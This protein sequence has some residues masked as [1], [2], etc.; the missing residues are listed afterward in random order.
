MTMRRAIGL[1]SGT[2]LDGIDVALIESDGKAIRVTRSGNDRVAAL[3]PT[4]YRGYSDEER[5]LLT[6][7]L[8]DAESVSARTDRPGC[9]P[10]AEAFLT[11]AHAEAVEALLAENGLTPADIAV[12]GFHGQTV[13]HRPRERLTVQIGDGAALARRL[14]I[15]VVADLRAEDVARGGQGAPLVPVFHRALAEAAGYAGPLAVLNIGGVANV[16][17]IDADGGLLAFDTGPGNAPVNDWMMEREGVPFDRD[18]STA[19]RGAVDEALVAW[20]LQ[21]PYFKKTPPKSLDRHWFS[22]RLAGHLGTADGAATLTAFAAR[23]IR[24]S[25]DHAAA[26]PTRWIVAGGGVKNR[27]LMAMLQSLLKAEIVNADDLGWSA[28]FLEAQ[29]FAYLALRSIEGLPLTVPSTTGVSAPAPG[30]V[31]HHP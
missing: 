19:A 13:M 27:T 28:D 14:R 23:A 9:L 4:A 3:G 31:L 18:G 16:T 30:G 20:L 26:R 6:R 7:A 11:R 24:A 17:L 1:M 22:H 12:V 8:R 15:P 5:A 21:H 29:A 10:E 25:L 2:S